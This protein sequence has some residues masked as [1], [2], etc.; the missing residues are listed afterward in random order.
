MNDVVKA[1]KWRTQLD[2]N[3]PAVM[4]AL[5]AHVGEDRFKRI[6]ANA[7]ASTP[8]LRRCM[9]NSPGKVLTALLQCA[10]DGLLPNGREAA[11][12]AYGGDL[13]YIPM[14]SGVLK[15]M[16]QSGEVSSVRARIV[17]ENDEFE[18]IYGDDERFE[19]KPAMSD[20]GEPV[21]AYAIIELSDGEVYREWMDKDDINAVKRAA[22][23]KKGPW[24]GPFELEMWR[25][26]VLKRAAKYCPMSA[27]LQDLMD[28]DNKLYDL[29]AVATREPTAKAKFASLQAA[30]ER[31]TFEDD[32]VP[33]KD[34]NEG[35]EEAPAPKA[36]A[37]KSGRSRE[38][39]TAFVATTK[40]EMQKAGDS[41]AATKIFEAAIDGEFKDDLTE[42][43][44]SQMTDTLLSI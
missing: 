4:E 29:D 2:A 7:V 28:R 1:P 23:A 12:V 20:R 17:H 25:K 36:K 24:A 27:D 9:E 22:K 16:R 13:T 5:P 8:D 15:R 26:T 39:V 42:D 11:L 14:I 6:A 35:L 19:H 38:D 44:V 43:D 33:E 10:Q 3:L 30:P 21:G 18:I 37:K 32:E 40:A 41:D 34:I 31:M